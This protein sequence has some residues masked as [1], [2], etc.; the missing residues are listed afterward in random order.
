MQCVE[1]TSQML[2]GSGGY[3]S[4]FLLIFL[5]S[6]TFPL[7][8]DGAATRGRRGR[9]SFL[10]VY[11]GQDFNFLIES[12]LEVVLMLCPFYKR[13]NRLRE[14][15]CVSKKSQILCFEITPLKKSQLGN[16]TPEYKLLILLKLSFLLDR[17]FSFVPCR[18]SFLSLVLSFFLNVKHSRFVCIV[19]Y[20]TCLKHTAI[21]HQIN[22]SWVW[23]TGLGSGYL[24]CGASRWLQD[25]GT[26]RYIFKVLSKRSLRKKLMIKILLLTQKYSFWGKRKGSVDDIEKTAFMIQ[27]DMALEG[28][29][30][31]LFFTMVHFSSFLRFQN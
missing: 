20:E 16:V 13:G 15:P 7:T 2:P 21:A 30:I 25:S 17:G 23:K 29:F 3:G 12:L 27:W 31:T 9:M 10:N 14:E 28:K 24:K 4:I 22:K 11:V 5:V 18:W 1:T 19:I 26:A 8:L 6:L